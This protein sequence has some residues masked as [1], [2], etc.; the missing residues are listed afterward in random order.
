MATSA[1]GA[2]AS[3]RAAASAARRNVQA[4]APVEPEIVS[5]TLADVMTTDDLDFAADEVFGADD[6]PQSR[7]Q[8]VNGGRA[9]GVPNGLPTQRAAATTLAPTQVSP[10]G[11]LVMPQ[12]D[13]TRKIDVGDLLI[14]KLRLTQAMSKTNTLFTT[15]KGKEGVQQGNWT[16][17]TQ[18]ENLGETVFFIPV[19]MRKSRA[20]FVPG[21]GLM[22]R[23]FDLLN[24]EGDP[25]GACEGSYEERL[26]IPADRRGCPL[27]LWINNEP[28]KCG[29]TYN[30]AG[31][32][33]RESEIE[34]PEKAKPM[35]VMLQLRSASTST[36]KAINTYVMNEGAGQWGT[37]ILELG[38]EVKTNIRG[39]FYVPTVD[40]YDTT[41]AE[42]FERIAR[43]A[44]AM[45]RSVSGQSLR[46]S[47]EDDER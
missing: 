40:F 15:S 27:R 25:G 3:R 11:A 19:D 5:E 23:S 14:P 26:T 46:S 16:V 18:N 34:D 7:T 6:L 43:R 22:C 39:T 10:A 44:R 32:V 37:V 45:A 41:D 30:Y 4:Q 9:A 20:Y 28:P 21:Q 13:L 42:G 12:E 29:Q 31:M 1:T 36:A 17:S 8:Q 24:G 47:I 35:Q 33:I 38:V 2:R